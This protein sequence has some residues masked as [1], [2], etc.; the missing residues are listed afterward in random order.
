MTNVAMRRSV[1]ACLQRSWPARPGG[2]QQA[3]DGLDIRAEPGQVRDQVVGRR[4]QRLVAHRAERVEDEQRRGGVLAQLGAAAWRQFQRRQVTP[5]SS[6]HT[7]S[8]G[9]GYSVTATPS[10]AVPNGSMPVARIR[11]STPA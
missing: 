1:A 11:R 6:H 5:A 7:T 4:R 10:A 9:S 3:A 8:P 2:R